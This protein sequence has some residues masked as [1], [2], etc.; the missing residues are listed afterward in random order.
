MLANS[1]MLNI[2]HP[3]RYLPQS[4]KTYLCTDGVTEREG[5]GWVDKRHWFIT[6]LDPFDI[7]GLIK[8]RDKTAAFWETDNGHDDVT[9][10]PPVEAQKRIEES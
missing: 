10:L 6:I 8:G 7:G 4:N 3:S 2:W 9:V 5:P 1:V